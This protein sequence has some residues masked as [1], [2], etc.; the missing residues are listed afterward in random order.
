MGQAVYQATGTCAWHT[1][2]RDCY[3]VSRQAIATCLHYTRMDP[4]ECDRR[5]RQTRKRRVYTNP[6]PNHSWHINGWVR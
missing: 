6:G 1:L 4:E 3:Q 5:G 2:R